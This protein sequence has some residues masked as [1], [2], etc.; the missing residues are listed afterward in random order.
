MKLLFPSSVPSTINIGECLV[1]GTKIGKF[2]VRNDGGAGKF[3]FIEK[4]RW[5]VTNFRVREM[6]SNNSLVRKKS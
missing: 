2:L 5:P 1:G 4:E 3:C 6:A